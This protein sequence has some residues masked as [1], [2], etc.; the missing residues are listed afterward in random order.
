VGI[1]GPAGLSADLVRRLHAAISGA[2]E[3]PDARVK[4][5]R[6]L[7]LPAH[8][9]PE[10]LVAEIAADHKRFAALVKASGYAPESGT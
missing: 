2:T 6:V 3:A 8:S 7:F 1:F 10:E 5:E 9:T 4:L